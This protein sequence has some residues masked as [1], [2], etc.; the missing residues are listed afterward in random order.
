MCSHCRHNLV[1]TRSPLGLCRACYDRL[2]AH[3][4]YDLAWLRS[5]SETSRRMVSNARRDPEAQPWP[6]YRGPRSGFGV[7]H[8]RTP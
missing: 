3:G 7:P 1:N 5:L 2:G 8:W 6:Q 4:R